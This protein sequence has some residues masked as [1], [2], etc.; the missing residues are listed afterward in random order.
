MSKDIE[1]IQG[2]L[3]ILEER[4][5][6]ATSKL[7]LLL[8][9]IELAPEVSDET[10]EI[11]R[12]SE[13]LIE[14]HWSHADSYKGSG[15]EGVLKQLASSSVNITVI[16]EIT[17]L[18]DYLS[19]NNKYYSSFESFYMNMPKKEWQRAVKKVTKATKKYPL[20]YLQKV[21]GVEM[22][23]LY[24]IAG[25]VIIFQP[26]ALI[27]LN[28]YG[29]VLKE[30]IQFKF[31]DFILTLNGKLLGTS[32]DTS[33]NVQDFLFGENRHMPPSEIRSGL[34]DIQKGKCIYTGA[35][36][37]EK[38]ESGRSL[39]HVLPWSRQRLSAIENFVITTASVNS[40]KRNVLPGYSMLE[41]WADFQITNKVNI[42]ALAENNYWVTDFD[43]VVG[44]L[45]S[46]YCVSG[47]L[48]P[49][50]NVNGDKLERTNLSSKEKAK[51]ETLLKSMVAEQ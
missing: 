31:T 7:G 17:E 16:N 47:D 6:T 32:D 37:P 42:K 9:L 25:R 3:T 26:G 38:E 39:D 8:A 28:V 20:I 19:K 11:D 27:S 30:M 1:P 18:K 40:R 23:F 35:K 15:S 5:F 44:N 50:I 46:I 24:K 21:G 12:I 45:T 13:K 51:I 48:T 33:L 34:S 36:L 14:I 41:K 2:I 49:V 4:N 10:L 22:S 29:A 43:R